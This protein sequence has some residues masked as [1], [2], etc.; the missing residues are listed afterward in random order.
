[1]KTEVLKDIKTAE[2]EYRTMIR[3]AEADKKKSLANAELEADNLIVKGEQAPRKSTRRNAWPMP[4]Q[5]LKSH[6]PGLS[7]KA[8]NAPLRSRNTGG[9][10]LDRAVELLVTRFKEQVHVKA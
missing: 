7:R 10:N 2:E 3:D 8:K 5:Q 4:G 6:M 1:M 9:K